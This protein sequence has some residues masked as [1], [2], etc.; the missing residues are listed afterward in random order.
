MRELYSHVFQALSGITFNELWPGFS[1]FKFAFYND[2][3]VYLQDS[4]I[5]YDPNF[6]GNTSIL[7]NGE[8]I[9]IWKVEN[10]DQENHLVL[11][12]N[13]VHE[14]FHAFQYKNEETRFPDNL[15][16]LDYPNN[17]ENYQLRSYEN[18]ILVQAYRERDKHKKLELFSE[19]VA[20]RKKRITIIGDMIRCEYLT[21]TVEGMAEYVGTKALRLLSSELF[22]QRVDKFLHILS[23]PSTTLFNIRR[24]SYFIGT[25]LFLVLDDLG[26]VFDHKIGETTETVFEMV[27]RQMETDNPV[28]I[29]MNPDP[30]IEDIYQQYL[31]DKTEAF[32]DFFKKSHTKTV[33]NYQIYGYDPM[34]TIKKDHQILCTHFIM[35]RDET[36]H[37]SFI[38]G[39]IIAELT[40]GAIDQVVAYYQLS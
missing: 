20:I 12:S 14:M 11:A 26:I 40:P 37:E 3:E 5:P 32:D 16:M 17:L 2:K 34:N 15:A 19:F 35:L 13:I 22:D 29:D 39:P 25:I 36:D 10:P 28:N 23:N 6:I 38:K 33:G 31:N 30:Q 7:Y 1:N 4:V 18:K 27:E 8:F 9:A 24:M 21:E